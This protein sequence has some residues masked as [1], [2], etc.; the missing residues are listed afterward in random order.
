MLE[1]EYRGGNSVV[2]HTKDRALALDPRV[3]LLGLTNPKK[4]DIEL[5]TEDLFSLPA[6]ADDSVVLMGPGEYEVGPFAVA[7]AMASR[8]IDTEADAPAST[9]YHIDVVGIRIG[10]LGNVQPKLS[11]SQLE[12]I[13]VV[14]ILIVPVGGGGYTLDAADASKIVRSIEPKVVIPVHYKDQG[15]TYEV[16]Q[17]GIEVF[18]SELGA[19]V[20]EADTLKIKTPAAIPP[21]L[22]VYKLKRTT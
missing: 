7:G 4:V 17:E 8:H 19:P 11:D 5:C 1:I 10:V 22:T 3:D 13:G 16:P 21:V 20:E 14:D 9:V 6:T 2:I 12:A 15:V 18:I